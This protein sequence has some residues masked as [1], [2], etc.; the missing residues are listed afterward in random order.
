M[1]KRY[2]YGMA[3][4]LLLCIN[5]LLILYATTIGI[6]CVILEF[7]IVITTAIIF[8]L[9]EILKHTNW[10][11]NVF[12]Y[13]NQ[14][15]SNLGY[16]N[17]L[18]RNLDIVNVGSNPARFGFH[19]ENILGENWS[20]GN[21]GL[22]MDFEII[23]FRHSF[24]RKGGCVL[25]PLVPFSSISGY[26]R[27][28]PEYCSIKYYAKFAHTLDPIQA[29]LIPSV[30]DARKWVR[31]PLLCEPKALRY[32]IIDESP[33]NRLALSEMPLMKP[34][35][36]EDARKMMESWLAE[37]KMK[38]IE[39]PL[40]DELIQGMNLS[41]KT[42]QEMID[43]LLERDLKPVLVLPAMSEPL[44]IYFTHE[45]KQKLV[46]DFIEKINR[47]TVKFLDY[48]D[49][50]KWQNPDLYFNSIF[51]NIRGRKLFT[52]QVLADLDLIKES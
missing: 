33:D 7:L 51:M 28:K 37:F 13:T 24:L 26:L 45:V 38:S 39:E 22:D 1:R 35:L 47:P 52:K 42:M 4:F 30:R 15:C 50:K 16:R 14:M 11:K 34:Q 5:V 43:F 17:Y 8:I 3:L 41:I 18:I 48:S 29:S 12:V 2:K 20:T 23:K 27:D 32:L 31:Y 6:I 19:Y 25:I 21:Q 36:I 49:E 40:S 46:Y 10:Y 44:Q 9:N